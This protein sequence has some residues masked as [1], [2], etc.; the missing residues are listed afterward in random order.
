MLSVIVVCK[1]RVDASLQMQSSALSMLSARDTGSRMI[2]T[3]QPAIMETGRQG[4]KCGRF[5][6]LTS[7]SFCGQVSHRT[8]TFANR[9]KA[10]DLRGA[11]F[12]EIAGGYGKEF[13]FWLTATI[14]FFSLT[15]FCFSLKLNIVHRLHST[16]TQ[17]RKRLSQGGATVSRSL[18]CKNPPCGQNSVTLLSA[19]S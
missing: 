6:V 16:R 13:F 3:G 19:C 9:E 11:R 17:T 15:N 12:P 4:P 5:D 1:V 18:F 14:L 2:R 10:R 7:V 8:N